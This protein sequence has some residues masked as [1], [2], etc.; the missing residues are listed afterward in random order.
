VP[1]TRRKCA[2]LIAGAGAIL[3]LPKWASAAAAPSADRLQDWLSANAITVRNADALDED[4]RDLEPLADR[5]RDA[6][7]VQLGEP[8]HGAGS[9]FAAKVRLVKFLHQRM[10]FDVLVWESGFY[11]VT[12][13][14]AGLA[15]GD[16]AVS[17][18]QRGILKIWSAS[19]E[20]RS[21]FEYARR[22]HGGAHPLLMSGFDMQ[23]TSNSFE[24]LGAALRSFVGSL[25]D[26]GPRRAAVN[27]TN[28][29][30]E[31]F[32]RLNKFV[33]ARAE[34]A[35]ELSRART[36]GVSM[37][38]ALAAWD[39][40]TG[41]A[42][43]PQKHDLDQLQR[44]VERLGKHLEG[45]RAAFAAIAGERERGF[46]SRVVVNLLGYGANMYEQF[47]I[48]AQTGSAAELIRENRR[49]ALNAQNLRWLTEEGYPGQKLIVW[50]HNVHVMNA[51]YGSDWK[52]VSLDP[53]PDAMKPMGVYLNEWLGKAVY[54]IGLTTY[55]GED[56]WVGGT[57]SPV[58]PAPEGSIEERL[59]RLGQPFSFLDM[60]AGRS[61]TD[62]PLR[63][64]H[65]A[66]VPK[67]DAT[68][69]TDVSRPY[70][71]LFYIERMKPA[72]LVSS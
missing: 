44:A 11:D 3:R 41:A 16:D 14:E 19:E 67:Y 50:A 12:R 65:V 66:R 1:I 2:C 38:E 23:L 60:R 45:H 57:P 54:T 68:E 59:H 55:G 47:R 5:I 21:V 8:S 18:A 35:A 22:S 51:Y 43:R 40:H 15:R 69:I 64:L 28:E 26:P 20:C 31:A 63:Q 30:L 52:S 46:M 4:W 13:T 49:D 34:R 42:L 37:D 9:A 25:R 48:D 33:E 72:T 61:G 36:A 32:A 29:G 56:A 10:G 27:A 71:G 53:A 58:A 39:R 7:I 17:S 6:R 62:G 24:E 70:D